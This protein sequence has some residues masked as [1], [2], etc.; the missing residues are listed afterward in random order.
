MNS[1]STV[2]GKIIHNVATYCD[3]LPLAYCSKIELQRSVYSINEV[4]ESGEE[5]PFCTGV[6]LSISTILTAAYCMKKY[7]KA[8]NYTNLR[9]SN[10]ETMH[11]VLT[12]ESHADY[13]GG[14]SEFTDICIVTVI[15][16]EKF[17]TVLSQ[18]KEMDNV[19]KN[20]YFSCLI[21]EKFCSVSKS[22]LFI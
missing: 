5:I 2:E 3:P 12:S 14:F 21:E 22:F 7:E 10:D 9:V 4:S 17:F 18:K 11:E 20:C 6:A 13:E 8:D 1:E 16:L 19:L 15:K